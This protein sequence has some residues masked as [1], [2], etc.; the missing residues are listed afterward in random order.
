V[1]SDEYEKVTFGLGEWSR[2]GKAIFY[3]R[4]NDT[5]NLWQIIFRDLETGIE[6]VLYHAPE[7]ET[8]HFRISPDGNWL[9]LNIVNSNWLIMKDKSK[10][11]LKIIP[12]AG[13]EP[14]ELYR[15]EER[16][17]LESLLITW[18]A[19]G[20]YIL[21]AR[22]GPSDQR[23]ELCRISADGGQ[24]EKLGLE[25]RRLFLMSV[26]PDGQHIAFKSTTGRPA[27]VWVMENFLPEAPVVKPEPTTT[28]R[29]IR[30]DW[31]LF[32]S[33]SPD[34]KY[35]SGVDWNTGDLL[36]RELATGKERRLTSEG[37]WRDSAM[38]P[39]G[40]RIAYLWYDPNTETHSL[41]ISKLDG[42]ARRLL[43]R[44]EYIVPRDWSADGKK[45]LAILFDK[46]AIQM[47]WVSASDG[48][49]RRI[50][51]VGK[52][53]FVK[54]DVSPDGRFIAYDRPQAE[55]TAKRDIFLLDVSGNREIALL[56]HPDDDKL[57][58]WTPDG[59]HVFFASDRT[60]TWDGWLLQVVGG[61]PQ[62]V[63][64]LVKQ[65]IGDVIPIGFT[66]SGS[67]YYRSEQTLRDVF[68][69]TLDLETG[70]V[71][72]EPMPVRQTGATT[73]HDWSPDGQYLAYCT[74]RP[75]RTQRI[76]IHT[77]ATGQELM[78]ADNIPYIRWLR[79]SLD[80]RS[81]L[82]DGFEWGDS[83]GVIHR[84]DVQTGERTDLVRST[85]EVLIRPELSPDGK[86]LFYDRA[87]PNL[88]TCR[89][90]ARDLQNGREKELFRSMPPARL[91]GSALSPDGQRF[92]LS[93]VPAPTR[94]AAP[95]LK[96]LSAAGG[97]PRELIQF[98]K[99]ENLRAV[100]VAWMPESQDVL[101]WKWFQ[102]GKEL[103]LWRISAEGGE[104]RKLWARKTLG[105]LRVHPD[106]QRIAFY[107]RSTTSETWV[108]ENFLPAAVASAGK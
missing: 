69:A 103:E 32:A 28:L 64:K 81:I 96:I 63:P 55:G 101:F 13:G 5:N 21:F 50:K 93:I 11:V 97:E 90:V 20:K 71:L 15:F 39:D 44:N 61:K 78:L 74:Q 102:G 14:R 6:K 24:P 88:K 100:G 41:Y 26:H 83:Q 45:I 36:I 77:L 58:G 108:M 72:S 43:R 79:W 1:L 105:H 95:V 10:R 23:W 8:F 12:A 16:I 76:Y 53:Y 107:S 73:C 19:D 68:M 48:S 65:N 30:D 35:L 87:D 98:D 85:T 94:P 9:A 4:R 67:Y 18:T 99:S 7:K 2:D 92:V 66:Q 89:L 47:V 25:M 104:P 29:K 84:I 22:K 37:S 106:G 80:G 51:S 56:T 75:D 31:G 62:G 70:K 57:L 91:T 34:G 42:S 3:A 52:K 86:T 46:D 38:S 60:G 40:N 27:E 59:E 17:L 54:Y 82:I 33:L 49:I